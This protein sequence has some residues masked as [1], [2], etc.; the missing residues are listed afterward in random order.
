MSYATIVA[1]ELALIRALSDYADADVTWG[2][3]RVLESGG[4]PYVILRAGGFVNEYKTP[5]RRQRTWTTILELYERMVGDGTEEV[6]LDTRRQTL[7]ALFDQY[8]TL[9][10]LSANVSGAH[11]Q[12][13]DEPVVAYH[14][15]G[16]G[17]F[18][19]QTMR[20]V[21]ME[22]YTVTASGEYD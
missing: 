16:G 4:D 6:N 1:K 18:L 15:K 13:G 7:I 14:D 21:V 10:A 17:V 20:L 19:M 8:P 2:D 3:Y 11:I 22:Q 9:D 5:T 12:D